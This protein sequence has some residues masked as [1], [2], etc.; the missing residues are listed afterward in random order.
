MKVVLDSLE[1]IVE[2]WDDPG[3][4]PSNAGSGPLPSY[5][6]V[7]GCDGQIVLEFEPEDFL[8]I[9]GEETCGCVEVETHPR[10]HSIKW[11]TPTLEM[12]DGKLHVIL[13]VKDC[14]G[15]IDT[16]DDYPEPF[17]DDR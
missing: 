4:Y 3:D 11:E 9:V 1:P 15:E 17:D 2:T 14:E 16:S 7:A 12:K 13:Q 8:T 10:I 6:Y 5:Q